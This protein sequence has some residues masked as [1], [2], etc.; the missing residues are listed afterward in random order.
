MTVACAALGTGI[1][2][3]KDSFTKSEVIP[4]PQVSV[5]AQTTLSYYVMD[6]ELLQEHV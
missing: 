2:S 5:V 6:Q 4:A 3:G 1:T